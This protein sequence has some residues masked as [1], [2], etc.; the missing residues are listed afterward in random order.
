M[1][2]S[3]L[4]LNYIELFALAY[5]VAEQVFD[6][7]PIQASPRKQKKIRKW[8]NKTYIE[9]D[10]LPKK[11]L[12]FIDS[13]R[14]DSEFFEFMVACSEH[15]TQHGTW[16]R[17]LF[18]KVAI[19]FPE[20]VKRAFIHLFETMEYCETIEKQ[21]NKI[22]FTLDESDAYKRKLILHTS[23][24][25]F[26]DDFDIL[27]FSDAQIIKEENGYKL[28]CVAENFEK[29]TSVPIRIFFEQA[30]TE[31]EI[32]RA[33]RRDFNDNPWESLAFMAFDILEKND[34]GTEY[35]NQKER[36]LIPLLKELRALSV[37]APLYDEEIHNFKILKQYITKHNLLHLIPLV[38]KIAAR[39]KNRPKSPLLL[40]RLTSKLNEA[41][42]E[43]LWRELYELVVDTQE[44]Y[45]DIILSY[46][47]EELN[48]IRFQIEETFHSLGY[49]GKYPNFNKKGAIKGIRLEESY[50][51]TYFVGAEK[52]VQHIVQCR[53]FF[54]CD[55]L[56]VQ[57]ICGTALLKKCETIDDVY[58]CCFN[59]NGRRLFKKF[60]WDTENT[61]NLNQFITIAS[62][63]AE[64][65]KLSKKEKE[66]LGN[67]TVTWQYF[68]SMFIFAGSL[69]AIL[70][71]AAIFLILCLVTAIIVGFG[72]ILD[73]I[74]QMPWWLFFAIGFVGF[75]GAMAIVD[76]KAKMK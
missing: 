5:S 57:F 49:E 40:L 1:D 3:K 56:N 48:K 25:S 52:N 64:C 22:I 26:V 36:D 23:E 16:K 71:T 15:I 24:E 41:I 55:T 42:C 12:N 43:S 37:W 68:I 73:M 61:D 63:K 7:E 45:A 62:K 67:G 59:K 74:K 54:N 38:D 32:Y 28:I 39:N 21:E 72:S 53:E 20:D 14:S 46:N 50:N 51:Q 34:L 58:S 2:I 18:E 69:F 13:S 33:D 65:T 11:V 29:E 60:C 30:T 6:I 27:G 9:G 19:D 8:V 75:G 44:E 17:Q 70:M 76:T 31:I 10:D 66:L 47:Q 35:F 4:D